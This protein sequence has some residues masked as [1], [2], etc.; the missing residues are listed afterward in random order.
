MLA[1]TYTAKARSCTPPS[2]HVGHQVGL[3]YLPVKYGPRPSRLKPNEWFCF[4]FEAE[5]R[6]GGF[7]EAKADSESLYPPL[8]VLSE[9]Q[10]PHPYQTSIRHRSLFP[11]DS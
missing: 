9:D 2:P 4:L 5:Y 10:L 11:P 1:L 6:Q 3:D 8:I 7:L